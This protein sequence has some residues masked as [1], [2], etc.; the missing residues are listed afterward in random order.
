MAGSPHFVTVQSG[1]AI[2]KQS[3]ADAAY[4]LL[5]SGSQGST[6]GIGADVAARVRNPLYTDVTDV[7]DTALNLTGSEM[8]IRL[9]ASSS[10]AS[11]E[12]TGNA[13]SGKLI[14]VKSMSTT[15]GTTKIACDGVT[16]N[17]SGADIMLAAQESR[18]L[19]YDGSGNWETY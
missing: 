6:T 4:A 1:N 18:I 19:V 10:D 17:G 3:V 13:V 5:V 11:L 9:F 2:V 12:V 16:V 14:M 7:T 15:G 8:R